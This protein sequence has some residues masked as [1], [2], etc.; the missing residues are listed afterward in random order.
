M[1]SYHRNVWRRKAVHTYKIIFFFPFPQVR[2]RDSKL[3][4]RFRS[5][6]SNHPAF[7]FANIPI[8]CAFGSLSVCWWI[9]R[10]N[11]KKAEQL[12]CLVV[13]CIYLIKL[14]TK[15]FSLLQWILQIVISVRISDTRFLKETK[16]YF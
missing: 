16:S 2:E 11:G 12:T 1:R 10:D 4:C 9:N 13:E 8:L 6:P 5:F 3:E 15:L 14:L 7:G